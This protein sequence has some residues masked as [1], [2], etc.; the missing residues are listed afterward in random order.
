MSAPL[1]IASFLLL[2]LPL[3]A[4]EQKK[5]TTVT[6]LPEFGATDQSAHKVVA[7]KTL[8]QPCTLVSAEDAKAVTSHSMT[9]MIREVPMCLYRSSDS[10]ASFTTLMI[11]L[12]E[13]DDEEM[14]IEVFRGIAGLPGKLNKM[15]NDQMASVTKKSAQMIEGLGD[16]A[17]LVKGNTDKIGQ[18][19]LVV[20][21][22]R[23]V[24]TLTVIGMEGNA[25]TGARLEALARKIMV[26]I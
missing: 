21:K 10:P 3:W 7:N 19:F 9:E 14:A 16:E 11:N 17:R 13:N 1:R 22:G 2:I 26:A 23:I 12:S 8:P 15:V 5:E 4:C 25:E 6:G 20:R 18:T 24:L